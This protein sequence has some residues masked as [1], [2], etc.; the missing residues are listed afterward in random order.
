MNV[1]IIGETGKP[2]TEEEIAKMGN[3]IGRYTF[4]LLNTLYVGRTY[5]IQTI[6]ALLGIAML[7]V[8]E[9]AMHLGQKPNKTDNNIH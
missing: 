1:P 3:E 7:N 8:T 4:G 6:G 2:L 5:N 9:N